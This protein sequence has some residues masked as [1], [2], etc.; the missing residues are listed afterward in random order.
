MVK[1]LFPSI[2]SSAKLPRQP[3]MDRLFRRVRNLLRHYSARA[4]SVAALKVIRDDVEAKDPMQRLRAAPWHTLLLVKW[5]LRDS[6]L[7]LKKM[8][9]APEKFLHLLRQTLWTHAGA[10]SAGAANTLAMMRSYLGVQVDYQRHRHHSFLRWPALIAS[11]PDN[12]ILRRQFRETLGLEPQEFI[13]VV[14][15]LKTALITSPAGISPDFFAPLADTHGRALEAV[16]RLFVRTLEELRADLAEDSHPPNKTE[17]L[18]FPYFVRYPILHLDGRYHFWDPIVAEK[19]F[20][21][22]VHLRLSS[23]KQEYSEQF[24]RAFEDYVV[25]LLVEAGLVPVRDEAF[26]KLIGPTKNAEA[27][28]CLGDANLIVEAKMGLFADP[29]L[30]KDNPRFLYEKFLPLR[31]AMRQG[32]DVSVKMHTAGV[33]ELSSFAEAKEDFLFIVTSRDLLV[34]GGPMLQ[35]LMQPERDL[36]YFDEDSPL[37]LRNTFIMDI[38]AF[39]TFCMALKEGRIDPT[40]ILRSAAEKNRYVGRGS[41][42]FEQWLQPHQMPQSWPWMIQ[43]AFD[44]SFARIAA[45]VDANPEACERSL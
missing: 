7:P 25:E 30:L 14:L 22:A 2:G 6:K 45:A 13:D 24:G 33:R 37:P 44:E 28:V 40:G 42:F 3:N 16:R 38:Q 21:R 41:M 34:S 11:R 27:I 31:K 29:M 23:L 20:E 26:R 1:L 19:A 15:A 8:D 17:L 9:A 18:E 43:S 10:F 39:E 12:S 35:Q 32:K 4:I 36:D 5:A